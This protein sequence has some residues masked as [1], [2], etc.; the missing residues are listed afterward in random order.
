MAITYSWTFPK[1]L[2]KLVDG[3]FQNVV[4]SVVWQVGGIDEDTQITSNTVGSIE[5][6]PPNV[7]DFTPY[8]DLTY[9]EISTWVFSL[10]DKDSI[11]SDL[12]I[13]IAAKIEEGSV[14]MDPPY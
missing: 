10:I 3:S 4:L 14:I 1:L 2:V 12:A 8:K 5:L 7:G 6:G 9:D 13:I 11:Q